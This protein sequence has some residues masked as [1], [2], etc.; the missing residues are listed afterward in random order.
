M[1]VKTTPSSRLVR[2]LKSGEQTQQATNIPECAVRHWR[3][4]GQHPLGEQQQPYAPRRARHFG[5]WNWPAIGEG[6]CG[7]PP[8]IHIWSRG[9]TKCGPRSSLI[10]AGSEL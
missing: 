10:D 1:Y 2:N 9:V 6:M 8:R 3:P 4:P 5:A 7:S